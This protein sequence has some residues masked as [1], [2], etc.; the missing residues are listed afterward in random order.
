MGMPVGLYPCP[1]GVTVNEVRAIGI[2]SG[3]EA[4]P[5]AAGGLGGAEG[6]S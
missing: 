3:A 6:S 2:L 1:A 4:I 5:I